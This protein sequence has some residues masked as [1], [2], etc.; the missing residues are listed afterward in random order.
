V[1]REPQKCHGRVVHACDQVAPCSPLLRL[2]VLQSFRT[3]T[4]QLLPSS[5]G[6][7]L[8]LFGPGR[9]APQR[10][11]AECRPRLTARSFCCRKQLRTAQWTGSD[12]ATARFVPALEERCLPQ[13]PD[14]SRPPLAAHIIAYLTTRPVTILLL[15]LAY[16]PAL[17]AP[18]D[19]F[20]L[21]PAAHC[22]SQTH[23]PDLYRNHSSTLLLAS[24]Q[25][26]PSPVR[27]RH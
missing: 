11:Q 27:H 6:L 9:D 3:F 12:N 16:L 1:D 21:L 2:L 19:L 8:L 14:Q 25:Y 5:P 13:T 26:V 15:R 24:P 20:L 10:L 18:P 23:S 17:P 7:H 4:G 22:T